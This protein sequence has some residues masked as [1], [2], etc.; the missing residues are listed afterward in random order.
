[1]EQI[2]HF[3]SSNDYIQDEI[4]HS[5]NELTV[6]AL[7]HLLLHQNCG[8]GNYLKCL[9]RKGFNRSGIFFFREN[10][11]E[12]E[13]IADFVNQFGGDFNGISQDFIDLIEN[14]RTI[15]KINELEELSKS[16][17]CK[18]ERNLILKAI[19]IMDKQLA[20]SMSNSLIDFCSYMCT[21]LNGHFKDGVDPIFG[22]KLLCSFII[23]RIITPKIIK[24][25]P[26]KQLPYIIPFL[27]LLNVVAIGDCKIFL[28]ENENIR[29]I[30]ARILMKRSES[31]Y[32]HQ[33]ILS[34]E[35]YN[36][37]CDLLVAELDQIADK[38]EGIDNIRQKQLSGT[39]KK[40]IT[41][42]KLSKSYE[43]IMKDITSANINIFP[44]DIKYFMLWSCDDIL[45]MAIVE[46][47]DVDF[48]FKWQINGKRFLSLTSYIL[49]EMGMDDF[50]RISQ[51]LYCIE[52][53][54]KYAYTDTKQ[55]CCCVKA[56]SREDLHI[57]LTLSDLEYLIPKFLEYDISELIPKLNYDFYYQVGI[58]NP[59]DISKLSELKNMY[60][61]CC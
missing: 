16:K 3:I 19:E 18:K 60:H 12:F 41:S 57:W 34:E 48:L 7:Y 47:L 50:N 6:E 58:T 14:E 35:D 26:E 39:L 33:V 40:K 53:I 51:I 45:S 21:Y 10:S 20:S 29:N 54:K 49:V 2:I 13:I 9:F 11:I 32:L 55:L 44:E 37:N 22:E 8:I 59:N 17:K 36:N 30:I 27:K 31:N 43:N 38:I 28:S 5:T 56:W 42:I 46:N 15:K 23:F 24:N 1:M 25:T 52:N 61:S 4:I